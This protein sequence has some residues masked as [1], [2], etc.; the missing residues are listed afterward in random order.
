MSSLKEVRNRIISVN[1]TQKI[2][3]AMKMVASAKLHKAQH[4]IENMLPYEQGMHGVLSHLLA[5]GASSVDSKY[6]KERDVENVAIVVFASNMSLCGSYNV[7][8]LKHLNEVLAE[9]SEKIGAQHIMVF[10]VGRK[11]ADEIDKKVYGVNNDFVEIGDKPSYEKAAQLAQTLMDLYTK[12]DVDKVELLYCHFKSTAK[13]VYTRE[14]FIP[15]AIDVSSA[16]DEAASASV[17]Y[18]LEPSA[19]DIISDMMPKV[20]KLKVFTALLD[21]CASEHGARTL[22]MQTATD[23]AN[24]LLQELNVMYNKSRQQSITNEI[25]D[26]VAGSMR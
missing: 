6:S 3:S 19:D 12:K 17:N 25:L 11:V 20:M 4:D 10:P 5:A 18:I 13:Q 8:M 26:I 22:A 23:N 24:D 9:Y 2:T 16:S 15:F 21:S 1:K 7:N 14:T